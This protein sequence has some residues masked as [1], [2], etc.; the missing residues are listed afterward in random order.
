MSTS[1]SFS[2]KKMVTLKSKEGETFEIDEAAAFL[3]MT[4]KRM[5][6][7]GRTGGATI[8]LPD[9]TAN[10]VRKVIEYCN[11]QAKAEGSSTGPVQAVSARGT[12]TSS[13]LTSSP[14]SNSSGSAAADFLGMKSLMDL[15]CQAVANMIKGKSPQEFC[16]GNF[17]IGTTSN[18][19]K[20]QKE[21]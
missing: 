21:N 12:Q 19:G 20:D 14:S 5:V 11:K 2:S 13:R 17:H 1:S 18:P 8:C 6:K 15:C 10:T 7:E 3:S 16:S 9:I 4:I